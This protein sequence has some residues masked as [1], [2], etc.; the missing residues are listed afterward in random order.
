MAVQL[1]AL[2]QSWKE[3]LRTGNSG[4]WDA[5]CDDWDGAVVAGAIDREIRKGLDGAVA[6]DIFRIEDLTRDASNTLNSLMSLERRYHDLRAEAETAAAD[7]MLFQKQYEALRELD[8]LQGLAAQ[9]GQERE[10]HRAAAEILQEGD[11]P[12][13]QGQAAFSRQMTEALGTAVSNETRR[14]TLQEQKWD[15]LQDHQVTMLARHIEPGGALNYGERARRVRRMIMGELRSIAAKLYALH[16]GVDNIFDIRREDL[17]KVEPITLEEVY[18]WL[19]DLADAVE[20]RTLSQSMV[21]RRIEADVRTLVQ[22]SATG[23]ITVGIPMISSHAERVRAVGLSLSPANGLMHAQDAEQPSANFASATVTP[24]VQFNPFAGQYDFARR[25]DVQ[26][27]FVPMSNLS[28]LPA[29]LTA[30]PQIRNINPNGNWKV[31]VNL[32]LD[33]SPTSE[34][35]RAEAV[36]LHLLMAR[37][38]ASSGGGGGFPDLMEE[39]ED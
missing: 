13:P 29:N 1:G 7:F 23:W 10:A 4:P 39:V 34:T 21:H 22:E 19:R 15:A 14:V 2:L 3:E 32:G 17:F 37:G 5:L 33:S 25:Q 12:M 27:G 28:E 35:Q 11:E 16:Y 8:T 9:R 38:P 18:V 6:Y 24:P 30:A 26:F 36:V 20:G 31:T